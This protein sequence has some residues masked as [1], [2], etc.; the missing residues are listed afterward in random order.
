[1]G[2][3]V[4]CIIIKGMKTLNKCLD[5]FQWITI[6]QYRNLEHQGCDFVDLFF[7]LLYMYIS[8]IFQRLKTSY[9]LHNCGR[10]ANVDGNEPNKPHPRNALQLSQYPKLWNFCLWFVYDQTL[11]LKYLKKIKINLKCQ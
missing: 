8:T 9:M 1:M 6:L 10:E 11:F 7:V 5:V 4:K 2:I 3:M